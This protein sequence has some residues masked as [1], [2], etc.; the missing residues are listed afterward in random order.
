MN[1]FVNIKANYHVNTESFPLRFGIHFPSD[2]TIELFNVEHVFD[3]PKD[4]N[5][6]HLDADFTGPNNQVYRG[7]FV[8]G[9]PI[10]KDS[11][12]DVVTV[13][14]GDINTEFYLSE[15][16][17]QLRRKGF[18]STND[19]LDM[20]PLYLDGQ[21]N[22][23]EGLIAYLGK[24][25][26]RDEVEKFSEIAAEAKDAAIL[27]AK[28]RDEALELAAKKQVEV[29]HVRSVAL[30]AIAVVENLQSDNKELK[31]RLIDIQN[32]KI[33]LEDELQKA[34]SDNNSLTISSPDILT[35]VNP[36]I[37]FKGSSCTELIF[38]D[39]SKKYMKTSTFD[40]DGAIT[41]HAMNLL[42]CKVKTTCWDPIGSP[43]R[44]SSLGYFRNIYLVE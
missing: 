18:L 38:S 44:W 34:K 23:S 9:K 17:K 26:S 1:Y 31:N 35:H 15:T 8:L 2:K 22:S 29:T 21:V 41:A 42:N 3:D 25:A 10:K 43:G 36:N 5:R 24:K 12:P 30:E 6:F 40:K 27:F 13:W 16:L 39:G 28:E 32:E 7:H 33:R 4:S 37:L 20:H 14:R 19:L 11:L